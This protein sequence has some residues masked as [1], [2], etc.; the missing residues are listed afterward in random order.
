M[1]ESEPPPR[2]PRAAAWPLI[3]RWWD[4]GWVGVGAALALLAALMAGGSTTRGTDGNVAWWWLIGSLVLAAGLGIRAARLDAD[5]RPSRMAVVDRFVSNWLTWRVL[6]VAALAVLALVIVFLGNKPWDPLGPCSRTE[7]GEAYTANKCLARTIGHR[8]V[9]YE[10]G[11]GT[12]VVR[13]S[14]DLN[15]V[16]YSMVEPSI[17]RYTWAYRPV[18]AWVLTIV[19]VGGLALSIQLRGAQRQRGRS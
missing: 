4:H 2:S 16:D 11:R 10:V 18:S 17:N 12:V 14:G 5:P 15:T 7:L 8:I 9:P 6:S 13:D 19:G 1:L 3:G